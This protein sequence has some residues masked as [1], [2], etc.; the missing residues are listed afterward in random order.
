MLATRLMEQLGQAANERDAATR[1]RDAA[2]RERAALAA[3]LEVAC[4]TEAAAAGAAGPAGKQRVAAP[5]PSAAQVL[6]EAPTPALSQETVL[7]ASAAS[8]RALPHFA[9]ASRWL[10][11][12]GHG[13]RS[14]K[15]I[16][17]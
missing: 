12:W 1:E 15:C 14:G 17:C 6:L 10:G 9:Q 16:S 5:E 11:S 2:V 4:A 13:L 3:Q 7:L 8:D